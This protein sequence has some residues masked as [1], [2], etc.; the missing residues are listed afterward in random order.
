MW[1]VLIVITA[2][3]TAVSTYIAIRYET[4]RGILCRD[5]HK[6]NVYVPCIGGISL[7]IGISVPLLAA[8]L[9]KH[10]IEALA[11][12]LAC[13]IATIVGLVDDLKDLDVAA[14]LLFAAL[15]S[16][17]ILVLHTYDPHPWIPFVGTTRLTIIYPL[18]IVAAYTVIIN[19]ANMIDTHNGVLV[20]LAMSTIA[21]GLVLYAMKWHTDTRFYVYLC[22]LAALAAYS[23]FNLYPSKIFNGNAGSYLIGAIL[24]SFAIVMNMEVFTI[25]ALMPMFTNGFYYISS[26][27]G[28]LKKEYV[29]RPIVV[30]NGVIEPSTDAKAPLTLARLT[31]VMIS[32]PVSEKELVVTLTLIFVLNTLL[33]MVVVE[34]LSAIPP[35]HH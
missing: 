3:I 23:Y 4:N 11:V 34:C 6:N 16:I 10:S 17:P 28:L 8:T 26:V 32:R 30:R 5:V 12:L 9:L 20:T 19:G 22:I 18:L 7:L 2:I 13:S 29:P 27:K 14:K 33:A 24:S 31:V 21:G 15:A 25:L 1:S 35:L